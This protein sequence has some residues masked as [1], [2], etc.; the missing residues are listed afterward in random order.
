MTRY[1]DVGTRGPE[2]F[3]PLAAMGGSRIAWWIALAL[4]LLGLVAPLFAA[5][6]PPLAD[7][8][9]H[10]ARA[11]FLALG[12]SDPVTARMFAPNW[13]VAPNLALDLILPPL[14]HVMPPLIAGKVLLGLAAVLP[15]TGTIALSRACFGRRSL[16]ALGVGLVVY[17]V[18]F[19]LGFLNFQIG[20][21]VA[22][23]GA[24]I[25]I[26]LTPRRP[27][28]GV[29]VGVVFGLMTFFSHL[30]AFGFFGLMI[31]C[32]E[33]AEIYRR[34]FGRTALR[35]GA[36]P[37]V[38]AVAAV[39]VLPA[40]L[41]WVSPLSGT[42]G[43]V[44]RN[45]WLPKLKTLAVPFAGYSSLLTYTMLAALALVFATLIAL[46]R[47]RVAPLLYLAFP[48]L[49]LVFVMLP[50]GAKGVFYIDTRIPVMLG[51]LLFGATLPRVSGAVGGAI[52]L[53]LT[54]LFV[55]RVALIGQVW[56][57]AQRD[58][59]AVR[60]VLARVPAGSRVLGVD[61]IP[62][63]PV[64]TPDPTRALGK[65]FP[66]SYWH[67]GAFA[68][69]DRRSFWADAFTLRG[70]QPVTVRP[71]FERS[72]NPGSFPMQNYHQLERAPGSDARPYPTYLDDWSSKF[73]YVLVFN[74]DTTA[75]ADRFLPE[76]L[77]P[78]AR[79]G[80]VML[81]EVKHGRGPTG[82]GSRG[83]EAGR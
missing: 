60:A 66:K 81:F 42:G 15:A 61:V 25:W 37:R 51:F 8:P 2:R 39:G 24:A 28:L 30:F 54:T 12:Q 69:I 35:E 41:Y 40:F 33:A 6:V 82:V 78:V 74:A 19:L 75:G 58:V 70:Q 38:A 32:A 7:Y 52:L 16:W 49:L 62:V 3:A 50:T 10:L 46:R 45:P 47:L 31:G 4:L 14:L 68:Y 80:F 73:D 63:E 9:N 83:N 29:I 48:L 1:G 13:A 79:K 5:A 21:G 44:F 43:A 23:W 57:D 55:L 67:Y 53:M 34:G 71:P 77:E 27:L 20:V 64:S 36:L 11:L 56:Y 59:D 65:Q 76:R 18:P 72:S 26:W 22:L 17:N